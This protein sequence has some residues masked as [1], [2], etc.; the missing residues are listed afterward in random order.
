[1]TIRKANQKMIKAYPGGAGALADELGYT[2][3]AFDNRLYNRK[4]Q[5][6]TVDEELQMQAL[7]NTEHFAEGVS[8]AS[9]GVHVP[10]PP[11]ENL[12]N[13]ELLTLWTEL[14]SELGSLSSTFTEAIADGA[15]NKKE[16]LALIMVG[17]AAMQKI[18]KLLWV[19]FMLYC[20]AEKAPA[21]E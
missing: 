18:Q 2:R 11:L 8:I 4:G 3:H 12:D 9:G 5:A 7:S 19:T 15:V 21:D 14:Y 1:M 13:E 10:I 20:P 17:S 16:K 6:F